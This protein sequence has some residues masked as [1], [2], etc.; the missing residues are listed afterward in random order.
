MS[1][2]IG[3]NFVVVGNHYHQHHQIESFDDLMLYFSK[4]ENSFCQEPKEN[5]NNSLNLLHFARSIEK[6]WNAT[7][8]LAHTHTHSHSVWEKY[9]SLVF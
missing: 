7:L 8:E 2:F 3:I 5:K 9:V 1:I 6:W 4:C